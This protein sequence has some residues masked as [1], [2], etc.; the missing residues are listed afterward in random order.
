MARTRRSFRELMHGLVPFGLTERKPRHFLEMA[1]IAWRNRDNLRYAW[2]VL[3]KGVCDGCA[4]GTTG[5]K[6]WTLDGTHLCLVR[7]NLL[8]LNTMRAFPPAV[9]GDAAALQAKSSKELR[10]MGRLGW[11]LRRRKGEAGFTPVPFAEAFADLGARWR[12]LDPQRTAMF[13]TS[14]GVTNEVYYVAQKVMRWLGSNHIDNSARLCHAPSTV[15]LKSAIGSA[16]TTCSYRDWYETDLIVFLGSNPANDQPVAMKYLDEARRRGARV[17]NVNACREPG[18]ERYWVPSTPSS[19]LFGTKMSDRHLLVKVG[20]DLALLTAVA[21]IVVEKEGGA[22]LAHDFIGQA[23]TGFAEYRALLARE[24]V[25]DLAA[26]AG[27]AVAEVEAFAEELLAAD[28]AILVWSM[29]ITHHADGA[30]AVKAIANL[31]LLR[32]WVGRPGCGLMPIRGHSGVQGGAE[33]GAYSTAFPGGVPID[34]ASA[35]RFSELWGFDVP[36]TPGLATPDFLDAAARGELDAFWCIGGNLLETMPDPAAVA[37]ALAKIPLRVHT[38]LVVTSQMLVPPADVAY[39]FPARTR[40]EQRGGGT[41]TSTERRVI[42]SPEIPRGDLGEARSEWELLLE[43]AR[44]VDPQRYPQVHFADGAAIRAEIERAVPLYRGIAALAKQ[45]DSF[46]YGGAH[47][48]SGRAF[49]TADGKAHFA[50]VR[51]HA[52][53]PL[54]ARATGVAADAP[55]FRLAT[56]RGKQFNSMIQQ[57]VDPLTGAARDHVFIAAVDAQRL[58]LAADEPI[59]VENALGRFRGRVFLADV[60]PGTLQGHWPEVNVLLPGDLREPASRVPDYNADVT[61]RRA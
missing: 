18:M 45:G 42:F 57:E 12:A 33:M 14:R 32:E 6:D 46:Q 5:L 1:K 31:A 34:A 20:G 16:A 24:S 60:A 52:D 37:A 4:L 44:A 54:T 50:C 58:G 43:L 13:V 29:G 21:K 49:P 55:T 11:P 3:S 2:Q 51:P 17:V 28:R 15:A 36:A 48:P 26:R 47:Y 35:R 8:R 56:R 27:L 53:A 22:R 38:D 39:V 19:A 59:V 40:Y 23:T 41:E 61:V 9:M 30:D 25:A 10:E 7:L